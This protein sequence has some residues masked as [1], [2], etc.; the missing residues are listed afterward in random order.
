MLA[1]LI[2]W[3]PTRDAAIARMHRALLELTIDGVATSRDFHLRVM[4]DAEFQRG[5]IDIQWL[6]RRLDSLTRVMRP[7]GGEVVAALAAVLLADRERATARP[8][9]SN[10]AT[11]NGAARDTAAA[12]WLAAARREAL[13]SR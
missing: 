9:A 2:V 11:A 12:G 10:G 7:A 8:T 13:R 3:A 5:A 6:E 1:K 4:E